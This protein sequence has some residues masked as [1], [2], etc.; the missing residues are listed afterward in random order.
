M[1]D[2][3]QGMTTPDSPLES[4]DL[5]EPT[6]VLNI[7]NQTADRTAR[8]AAIVNTR[9]TGT[10][11]LSTINDTTAM[12]KDQIAKAGDQELRNQIA[13]QTQV[14]KVKQFTNFLQTNNEDTD[15]DG[16]LR[17]GAALASQAVLQ[18][19]IDNRAKYA[20]EQQAVDTI[21]DMAGSDPVQAELLKHNLIDGNTNQVIRDFSSKQLIL[22]REIEN[23]GVAE[24]DQSWLADLADFAMGIAQTTLPFTR[25]DIG[26]VDYD[27]VTKHWYDSLF[28]GQRKQA[29]SS[30]LWNMPIGEFGGFVKDHLIPNLQKSST[31]L[32]YHNNSEEL[33][34]L[35]NLTHP[36]SVTEANVNDLVNNIGLVAGLKGPL[37]AVVSVPS[38]L[39]R[40]GARDAAVATITNALE[41]STLEGTAA[42]AAKSGLSEADLRR[43]VSPTALNID[44]LP[45]SRVPP[46]ADA[47]IAYARGQALM[48]SPEIRGL[49]QPGRFMDP[50]EKQAILDR[51]IKA[52][53]DQ[54][55]PNAW[56]KD[57][58]DE[59]VRLGSGQEVTNLLV[60]LGKKDFGGF[61]TDEELEGFARSLGFDKNEVVVVP[62]YT[63]TGIEGD[64]LQMSTLDWESVTDDSG[65]KFMQV[66]MPMR[67]TGMYSNPLAPQATNSLSRYFLNARKISDVWL[68]DLAQVSGNTRQRIG[69][70][71]SS[72]LKAINSLS[73]N[74]LSSLGQVLQAGINNR[75]WYTDNQIAAAY[76]RTFN[77]APSLKEI[78]A[79]HDYMDLNDMEYALRTEG[80]WS[81]AH[82]KG[83][84]TVSIATEKTGISK[85]N[86]IVDRNPTS[87]PKERVYDA[88]NDV[89]YTSKNP[90]TEEKLKE[91]SGQG[92][93]LV[94]LEK[95][96]KLQDGTYVK[97]F[98]VRPR[99]LDEQ[100][101]VRNQIGYS[102]GGHR[103]YSGGWFVKQ[104]REIVQP[105]TG[106]KQLVN[107]N[108]FINAETT[109]DAKIFADKMEFARI[110]A[111][112]GVNEATLDKFFGGSPGLPTGKEFLDGVRDGTYSLEHKFE[113]V[114]DRRLPSA[115]LD[116]NSNLE[117]V[118]QDK[119]GINGLLETQ[120]RMYYGPK[121]DQLRDFRGDLAPTLDPYKTLN[122]S[123]SNIS[124]L[125]SFADYKQAAVE[126]WASTFRKYTGIPEEANDWKVFTE[127]QIGREVPEKI[128]QGA[129]AQREVINRVLGHQSEFDYQTK[130]YYNRLSEW[131]AG[132]EPNQARNLMA[133]SVNWWSTKDPSASIR[134]LVFDAKLGFW[135]PVQVPIHLGNMYAA[136]TLGGVKM[137]MPALIARHFMESYLTKAGTEE[138]LD[139][140]V[141]TGAW[142]KMG[143]ESADEF[144]AY[145]RY[146]KN[147]GMMNIGD[148]NNM[149]NEFGPSA[150][151][152]AFN[153]GVERT[154][155][156]GRVLL[157][158]TW[159]QNKIVA[160]SLA[161]QETKAMFPTLAHDSPEF[162]N[163]FVGRTEEYDL[164]FSRESRAA[165]QKGWTSIPTQFFGYWTALAD[166]ALGKQFTAAQRTRLV[167]GQLF[168]GGTAGMPI[169]AAADAYYSQETGTNA[170]P[171]TFWGG[172]RRGALDDV[173]YYATG[174]DVKAGARISVGDEFTQMVEEVFG[175]GENGDKSLVDVFGGASVSVIK[176]AGQATGDLVRY[177]AMES[178]GK[179]IGPVGRDAV[180]RV[181]RQINTLGNLTK[182]Y[183]IFRYGTLTSGSGA[184]MAQDVP[185]SE[186]FAQALGVDPEETVYISNM[187]SHMKDSKDV[188]NDYVKLVSNYRAR[189]A[190]EPDN[191]EDIAKE[192]NAAM[193]LMP[194]EI[195]MKVLRVVNT[196]TPQSVYKSVGDQIKRDQQK[197]QMMDEVQQGYN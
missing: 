150:S 77:R 113:V 146:V 66:K 104:A 123:L 119:E 41:T 36:G 134:G 69:T 170:H 30:S 174:A 63:K 10:D 15:P 35:T 82:L 50:V 87:V 102:Q 80:V 54:F 112:S 132:N 94:R 147:S 153:N 192:I 1:A 55:A 29:E 5:S 161:W 14:D 28:S 47:N 187:L 91:L 125:T 137:G 157:H 167:L 103:I 142:K 75:M 118:D 72:K 165:W 13:A 64:H 24:K 86:G 22:Q 139:H 140:V 4:V 168:L 159:R 65:Q 88:V 9:P 114:Q 166:A 110:A 188:V 100:A 195:R 53:Y 37:K 105:D 38:L 111:R 32:G 85:V 73:Q 67:E 31:F 16:S 158:W 108:T 109:Q 39:V 84:R 95:V 184:V 3:F 7:N 83:Y 18:E 162:L 43:S 21:Q 177:V 89:H 116:K 129:L 152:S 185:T 52:V 130:Q 183:S 92:A 115:Y 107:P 180:L 190:T 97:N 186:G 61:A 56:V 117:Y 122:L 141:S 98:L 169:V 2:L 49:I 25:G 191:R 19:T 96:A 164:N 26:V 20:L 90:I 23:A 145:F 173:I 136:L 189:F 62:A 68:Q 124:K 138:W 182:A 74:E 175:F 163:K 171:D 131:V 6:P 151:L 179:D 181:A 42:S 172:L 155:Q 8:L 99:D 133:K 11:Y 194:P 58:A 154:R 196:R 120:G 40:Q 70:A 81:Q 143:H 33:S 128:R 60:T 176:S 48:D 160:S 144:K 193:Q 57:V 156:A 149:I 127:G 59:T 106:T 197:K 79:Y 51:N 101:L 78:T 121:G 46:A 71:L 12:Y 76:E 34:T 126:R 17:Q 148:A 45:V 178:G 93:Y 135:N 44:G 27:T